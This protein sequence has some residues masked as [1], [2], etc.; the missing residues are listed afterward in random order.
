MKLKTCLITTSAH[1]GWDAW[2]THLNRR[3]TPW[4]R[5]F[6]SSWPWPLLL[7]FCPLTR[8]GLLPRLRRAW[9]AGEGAG[10][11]WPRPSRPFL[12]P[13]VPCPLGPN[14]PGG[15]GVVYKR[16][17]TVGITPQGALSGSE[18]PFFPAAKTAAH[19]LGKDQRVKGRK[20]AL[21]EDGHP[22][23]RGTGNRNG[24]SFSGFVRAG[25]AFSGPE[26]PGPLTLTRETG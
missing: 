6:C 15:G 21:E 9:A 4:T 14:H 25:P 10:P 1:N 19:L 26:A 18:N 23:H 3:E 22:F 13:R 5:L 2:G 12:P 24:Q 8:P 20:P 17:A 11:A 7:S 16:C